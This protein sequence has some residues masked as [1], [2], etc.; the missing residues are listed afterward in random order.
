[1][2][3]QKKGQQDKSYIADTLEDLKKIPVCSMGS[4][5]YVIETA[6]KYMINSK[7]EWILQV[8]S[9][10]KNPGSFVDGPVDGGNIDA[11]DNTGDNAGDTGDDND[12][13]NIDDNDQW[14]EI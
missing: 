6:E 12:G 8:Y 11:G 2:A 14:E 4:T 1:M 9:T 5:C 13:G 10:S 7:G 3:Y